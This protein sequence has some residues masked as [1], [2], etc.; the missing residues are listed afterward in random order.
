MQKLNV[1][2]FVHWIFSVLLCCVIF[3]QGKG[4]AESSQSHLDNATPQQQR[5]ITNSTFH[6]NQLIRAQTPSLFLTPTENKQR[7]VFKALAKRSL[8]DSGNHNKYEVVKVSNVD[9]PNAANNN[10]RVQP[11]E[12]NKFQWKP[13]FSQAMTFLW[14]EH[15]FRLLTEPG[16]RADLKGPFFKDWLTA[17]RNTRGWRDGDPFLVNY[18]GHPMQGAVAGYIFVHNDPQSIHKEFELNKSYFKSRLKAMLFSTVYSTQF[19]LGPLSEASLGNVGLRP[20]PA[21]KHP[22]AFVDIIVTPTLGAVWM[23]GEDALDKHVIKWVEDH[24]ENRVVR[25]LARSFLNPSRCMANFL[26]GRWVWYR[27]GRRL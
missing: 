10:Q 5:A 13:A 23:M 2:E 20:S 17:V 26:R 4:C 18:I 24:T 8:L 6:A 3:G 14:I 22:S 9:D 11:T 15:S 12:S 27:D 1:R 16:T 19:E 21:S 7:L 25:I